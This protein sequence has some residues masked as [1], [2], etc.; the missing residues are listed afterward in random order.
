[1]TPFASTVGS[2]HGAAQMD[3]IESGKIVEPLVPPAIASPMFW[4]RLLRRCHR[5]DTSSVG[6]RN[7]FPRV[8][9]RKGSFPS[10]SRGDFG[11]VV[12]FARR[13]LDPACSIGNPAEETAMKV[14]VR[15]LFV[16]VVATA[17][18]FASTTQGLAQTD[19]L[20]SWNDGSA[21]QAIV[22]FVR[23]TTD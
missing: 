11:Q 12:I 6:M 19:P 3:V 17:V 20:S 4:P 14:H 23:M 9:F 13:R 21:K 16:F 1:R 2:I 18:G 22:E 5:A 15:V 8:M 7:R 10:R